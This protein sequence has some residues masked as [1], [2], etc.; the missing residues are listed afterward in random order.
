MKKPV[1]AS[2]VGGLRD[3]VT[4]ETGILVPPGNVSELAQGILRLLRAPETA[5]EK[6][7]AGSRTVARNHTFDRM[8]NAILDLY[9]EIREGRPWEQ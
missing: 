7:I 3:I 8:M 2:G 6:G 1:V 4:E 9:R 5:R